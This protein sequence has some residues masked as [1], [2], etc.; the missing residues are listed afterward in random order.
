MTA[1]NA[2]AGTRRPASG[3]QWIPRRARRAWRGL[4]SRDE[5]PRLVRAAILRIARS[6]QLFQ[7]WNDT[8]EDRYPEVFGFIARQLANRQDVRVLS[9]GCSTGEEVLSLRRYLP[10]AH[11]KGVDISGANIADCRR[12]SHA[13][14]ETAMEF[15]RAGSAAN[16]P[17]EKYDAVLAMAVF[18][19]GSVH[20]FDESCA[21]RIRFEAFER[22]VTELGRCLR[23]GGLLAVEH[24]NF[25]FADTVLAAEF[26]EVLRRPRTAADAGTPLFDRQDR[27]IR[28]APR[29]IGVVF[30]KRGGPAQ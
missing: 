11:L 25:R 16:E 18:R 13:V 26:E 1:G 6:S 15:E 12:R 20:A 23:P 2:S 3:S 27:R 19:H 10:G 24:A 22:S 28:P 14:G 17:S 4:L 9:F 7:P 8:E 5:R 30:R 29:H 21:G